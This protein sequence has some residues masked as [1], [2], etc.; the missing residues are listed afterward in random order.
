[1]LSA[2]L[3]VVDA[4]HKAG[5]DGFGGLSP[6]QLAAAALVGPTERG[7]ELIPPAT[8][9][10][11]AFRARSLTKQP[12]RRARCRCGAIVPKQQELEIAMKAR[13]ST[14]LAA[15]ML[16][17]GVSAAFAAAQ[18][19][20]GTAMA[21]KPQDTL[22][23]TT[24]QRQKAWK[25]LYTSNLN[26]TTPAGINVAVGAAVPSKI[27]TA[28]VWLKAAGDVPALK[29]YKFA[30]VDKKLVIANPTDHKIVDVITR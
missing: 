8:G 7:R 24:A 17:A 4:R 25:D 19:S 21:A 14:A 9:C 30:I 20:A 27:A 23:L 6:T 29:P 26:Q 22:T 10:R 11:A 28:S 1:L 18:P 12:T 15:A 5:H 2:F 3:E 16:L 13:H